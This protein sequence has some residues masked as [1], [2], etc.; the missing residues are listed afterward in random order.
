LDARYDTVRVLR[1]KPALFHEWS[2]FT[3]FVQ[4]VVKF[5]EDSLPPSNEFMDLFSSDYERAYVRFRSENFSA[6]V[7][8][9]RFSLGPSPRYNLLL[10]GYSAPMDWLHFSLSTDH[11]KFSFYLS[12]LDDMYTKPLEYIGDTITEFINASRYLSIRRLDF[13]PTKWLNVSF[14]EA[15]TFGGENY[16]L[17]VYHFNPAIL[18]HTYQYNWEKDANLFFHLDARIFLNNLSFY[19]ALFVDD[20]QLEKDP[21]NESHHL[22]F[23]CGI[24]CADFLNLKRTFWII[25]YTAL[26]RYIYCHFTPYQRYYYAN[27]PI[28]SQF[29][30]DYDE[31]YTKFVYH[32][33][34]KFDLYAQCSYS[35]KGETTIE[36]PWPIPEEPR[37]PGTF[38]PTDNF[39]SGV[40]QKS[41]D[42]GI[43]IRFF[44]RQSIFSDLFIGYYHINNFRHEVD[45]TK[46]FLSFRIQLS[47]INFSKN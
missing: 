9:E 17:E 22:G 47:A 34:P 29:G 39:L 15:A 3:I 46:N 27:T 24:E 25:E 7:G 20:F 38:F 45:N 6:F 11:L 4:P 2:S 40:V 26:S 32:L 30:P 41:F 36:T 8:R 31:L 5:G 21:N 44:H 18:L 16:A 33:N 43:G 14:S 23:N 1:L 35:R 19:A 28:G 12:R 37:Q 42:L 10:S 13:S